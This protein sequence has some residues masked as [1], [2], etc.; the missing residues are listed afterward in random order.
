MVAIDNKSN[1]GSNLVGIKQNIAVDEVDMLFAELFSLVNSED[2]LE[3]VNSENNLVNISESKGN[4]K[5]SLIKI[6][7]NN[8]QKTEDLAKSLV[9]IFYK[10]LGIMPNN[11]GKKT[12]LGSNELLD[13]KNSLKEHLLKLDQNKINQTQNKK[14][15]GILKTDFLDKN[16][17]QEKISVTVSFN[18]PKKKFENG[19][20]YYSK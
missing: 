20:Y 15:K 8:D 12:N 6:E 16:I 7:Q 10:D 4:S 3:N 19:I 17:Q 14:Q 18:P 13:K 5:L 9:Q 2:E 11:E 1:S